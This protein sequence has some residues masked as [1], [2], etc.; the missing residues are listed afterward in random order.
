MK[1]EHYLI[2]LTINLCTYACILSHVLLNMDYIIRYSFYLSN[3]IGFNSLQLSILRKYKMSNVTI[4]GDGHSS[5]E[6]SVQR[7]KESSVSSQGPME[8]LTQTRRDDEK[9]PRQSENNQYKVKEKL[10]QH[11]QT[12]IEEYLLDAAP[13][14]VNTF[15][16]VFP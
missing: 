4:S 5:R 15:N 16:M 6:S 13:V 10:E 14:E 9:A 8:A 2:V 3:L 12:L 7:E 11:M 1:K